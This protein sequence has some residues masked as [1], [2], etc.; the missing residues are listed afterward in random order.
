[1]NPRPPP[2]KNEDSVS[3]KKAGSEPHRIFPSHKLKSSLLRSRYINE[4]GMER[5][6]VSKEAS[7]LQPGE[8]VPLGST[9]AFKV[10]SVR[11]SVVSDSLRLHAL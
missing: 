7:W 2:K 3:K 11:H 4:M 9:V 1:M 8:E 6:Q 10:K 5:K